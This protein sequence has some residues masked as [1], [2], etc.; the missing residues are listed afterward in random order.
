MFLLAEQKLHIC[1]HHVTN[2]MWIVNCEI[3]FASIVIQSLKV[4]P[5]Y[6]LDRRQQQR[7]NSIGFLAHFR[8]TIS[9]QYL[10]VMSQWN[11]FRSENFCNFGYFFFFRF[12]NPHH[13]WMHMMIQKISR[14]LIIQILYFLGGSYRSPTTDSI[15]EQ[16]YGVCDDHNSNF[17]FSIKVV[18]IFFFSGLF[19]Y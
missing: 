2:N 3:V 1:W 8:H 19:I 18:V 16:G 15:W 14:S 6:I 17:S 13:T 10:V 11:I 12:N 5:V 4:F 9:L 7:R